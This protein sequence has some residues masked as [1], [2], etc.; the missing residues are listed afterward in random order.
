MNHSLGEGFVAETDEVPAKVTMDRRNWYP[1]SV[2]V[3]KEELKPV[4]LQFSQWAVQIWA[5]H[6]LPHSTIDEFL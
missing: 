6:R 4:L 2:K 3:V 1:K 5:H